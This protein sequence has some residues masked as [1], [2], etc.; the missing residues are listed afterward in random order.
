MEES[1]TRADLIVSRTEGKMS[2]REN[3]AAPLEIHDLEY[4]LESL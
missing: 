2:V 3:T 4:V 1:S